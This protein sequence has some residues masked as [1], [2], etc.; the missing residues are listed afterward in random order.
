M[1]KMVMTEKLANTLIDSLMCLYLTAARG[2]NRDIEDEFVIACASAYA[3][4]KFLALTA[5][6][7]NDDKKFDI[8]DTSS[9]E[10]LRSQFYIV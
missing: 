7:E 8:I 5:E 9:P 10:Y 1:E 2:N 3:E 6:F 4:E